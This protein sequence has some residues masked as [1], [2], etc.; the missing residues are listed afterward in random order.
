M[1]T[2]RT[3]ECRSA[4]ATGKN[5]RTDNS[6]PRSTGEQKTTIPVQRPELLCC[7]HLLATTPEEKQPPSQTNTIIS[8]ALQTN[9]QDYPSNLLSYLNQPYILPPP[10]LS[11]RVKY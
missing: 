5:N 11:Y 2:H 6:R 9:A 3:S 4:A 10:T 7:C 1:A 8:S